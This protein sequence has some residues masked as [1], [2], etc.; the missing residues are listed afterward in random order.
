MGMKGN[1]ILIS[2]KKKSLMQGHRLK[3]RRKEERVAQGLDVVKPYL[4]PI[5]PDEIRSLLNLYSQTG[6]FR[7]ILSVSQRPYSCGTL[8]KTDRGEFF[9]K[10]RPGAFR[11]KE[12]L[13]QEHSLIRHLLKKGIKTPDVLSNINSQTITARNSFLYELFENADGDD[14]YREYH[15]WMPFKSVNHAF[16]AGKAL[17][18]FHLALEDFSEDFGFWKEKKNK[19]M[20]AR[21]DLA[22]SADMAG[23]IEEEIS[24][25]PSLKNFFNEKP[26]KKELAAAFYPYYQEVHSLLPGIEEWTTHGDWHA[27]NLF[28]RDSCITS[29]IDFHLTERTFRMY[30]LAVAIDRNAILW[31]QILE[32]KKD[33][34]RYDILEAILNGY[35]DTF[36]LKPLDK[37]I[38]PS[39]LPI[40]QLDLAMSNM[41]YYLKVEKNRERAA[42]CYEIYIL[43]HVRHFKSRWGKELLKLLE[44]K[45]A[46]L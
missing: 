6:N 15:S 37:K 28:F 43:A 22:K 42:W 46:A 3:G 10:K 17:A 39:L 26:W 13:E 2:K 36:P 8:F 19:I 29:V 24:R 9:V 5:S 1:E 7:E 35:N 21:F 44:K 27:N 32:G 33:R 34:V 16:N 40:H 38:L 31:L 18:G 45:L 4:E 11:D 12:D 20:A 41:D 23:A 14:L 30:D 25:R